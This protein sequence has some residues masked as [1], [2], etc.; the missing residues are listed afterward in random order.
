MSSEADRLAPRTPPLICRD[1]RTDPNLLRSQFG[2]TLFASKGPLS[3]EERKK[4]TFAEPLAT[5]ATVSTSAGIS[6][7]PPPLRGAQVKAQEGLGTA[8]ALYD[9][10]GTDPSDL[11]CLEGEVLTVVE[12]G[13]LMI[14]ANLS[15]N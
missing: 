14:W 7:K 11:P 1:I 4:N 6:H 8:T 9:Y 12:H 2:K 5:R 13:E 15:S 3:S 10:E